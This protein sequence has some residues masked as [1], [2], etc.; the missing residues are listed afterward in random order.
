LCCCTRLGLDLHGVGRLLPHAAPGLRVIRPDMRGHGASD[1]PRAPYAMGALIRDTE[2]LLDHLAIKEAVILGL[3]VGGLIAQGLAVKRL[4]LVRGLILSNT[5]ARLGHETLW[6]AR[7]AAVEQGGLAAIATATMERWFARAFR[8][9]GLDAPWRDR[10]LSCPPEGWLG[11]A[12]AIAGTD[13][14]TP[15]AS[16]T[17]P[18]LVIAGTEDGSTPPDLV[19]ETADLLAGADFCLIRGAGHLPFVERPSEYAAAIHGFLTRIAHIPGG[20]MA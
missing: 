7:I 18:A 2:R 6:Q 11:A 8:R 9:E 13:F 19:R 3:S 1:V 10:L 5:A 20:T 14:Y 12:A 16:L 4:D 17:L 15:T